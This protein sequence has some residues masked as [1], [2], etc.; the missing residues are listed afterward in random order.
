M[1]SAFSS[2]NLRPRFTA[3]LNSMMS[4]GRHEISILVPYFKES[5]KNFYTKTISIK[6]I[7]IFVF[8]IFTLFFSSLGNTTALGVGAYTSLELI[9]NGAS[10][11]ADALHDLQ[12]ATDLTSSTLSWLASPPER[13]SNTLQAFIWYL[14][15]ANFFTQFKNSKRKIDSFLDYLS[16]TESRQELLGKVGNTLKLIV[17][18]IELLHIDTTRLI[19][20]SL[21]DVADSMEPKEDLEYELRFFLKQLKSDLKKLANNKNAAVALSLD[22]YSFIIND[23]PPA[24]SS[25]ED[26]ENLKFRINQLTQAIQEVSIDSPTRQSCKQKNCAYCYSGTWDKASLI[27]FDYL[28]NILSIFILTSIASF[29]ALDRTTVIFSKLGLTILERT[30]PIVAFFSV[31]ISTI[32]LQSANLYDNIRTRSVANRINFSKKIII[33]AALLGI[34]SY[35][36]NVLGEVTT[37]L[38]LLLTFLPEKTALLVFAIAA[39]ELAYM[40]LKA[41]FLTTRKSQIYFH[42]KLFADNN[43]MNNSFL[44]L[45][46]DNFPIDI[47]RK[48][49]RSNMYLIKRSPNNNDDDFAQVLWMA[50]NKLCSHECKLPQELLSQFISDSFVKLV[51]TRSIEKISNICHKSDTDL[52]ELISKTCRKSQESKTLLMLERT[53]KL[54]EVTAIAGRALI[55]MG[56][57][58]GTVTGLLFLI[59]P[60]P[61]L[62]LLCLFSLLGIMA[63]FIALVGSAII[64]RARLAVAPS[65][66][67]TAKTEITPF[68]ANELLNQMQEDAPPVTP[69]S[70]MNIPPLSWLS[71]YGFYANKRQ[72]LIVN[73]QNSNPSLVSIN[74]I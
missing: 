60:N 45:L 56:N 63:G 19:D 72:S 73:N 46:P 36:S 31:F 29:S 50:G 61:S 65:A 1:Y 10:L 74:E 68:N 20:E 69:Q 18:E 14:M 21:Q 54:F 64:T 8:A 34:Q 58:F 42:Q 4:C 48:L 15:A 32:T 70:L 40:G 13:L 24:L 52:I 41:L 53:S 37:S 59:V 67:D 35:L 3:K 43:Q 9:A 38:K 7:A 23:D 51:D 47:I 2:I 33:L 27:L 11:I 5:F 30:M 12:I 6:S 39:P 66:K 44:L 55:N 62:A 17:Q 28:P 49:D 16:K 26:F 25:E 71:R 22:E 57:F